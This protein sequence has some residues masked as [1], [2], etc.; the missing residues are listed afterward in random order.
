MV[1]EENKNDKSEGNYGYGW[2][3]GQFRGTREI[4]HNGGLNGFLSNLLRLPEQS[5]TVVVLVN[6]CPP[7]P[8]T[9][10]GTLSHEIA[11]LFLGAEKPACICVI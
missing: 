5:F 1:T 7:K 8:R 11:E 3:I 6:E 9:D 4:S 10:P 2:G